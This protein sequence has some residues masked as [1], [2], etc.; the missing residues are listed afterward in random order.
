[1]SETG[2]ILFA[3]I[4]Y[5]ILNLMI[6]IFYGAMIM[7]RLRKIERHLGIKPDASRLA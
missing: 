2:T 5:G 6:T 7:Q 3:V 4:A 1:M